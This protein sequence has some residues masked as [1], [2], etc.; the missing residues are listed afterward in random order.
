MVIFSPHKST[1]IHTQETA[2]H[3]FSAGLDPLQQ[4]LEGIRSRGFGD[5]R[6]NPGTRVRFQGIQGC[7]SGQASDLFRKIMAAGAN[8]MR[9]TGAGII[10]LAGK[11]L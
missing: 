6:D 10:Y 5:H 4:P 11:L 2:D 3:W 1:R 7:K 8:G 9:N